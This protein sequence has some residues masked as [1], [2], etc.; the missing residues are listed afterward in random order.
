MAA[1][2]NGIL[3]SRTTHKKA[4]D[5][6]LVKA[7]EKHYEHFIWDSTRWHG[8][9]HRPDDILVCTAYKAGTTW[10]QRICSLL[11][12]QST[13]LVKP[14]TTF[15][16]WLELNAQP[17]EKLHADYA[18]QAHRRFIKTHTPLDGLPW[19]DAA[20]Y[21][22]VA[23]DPRDIFL[24]MLNH[25]ANS[26]DAAGEILL[27]QATVDRVVLAKPPE[28]M[29]ELL[30]AWL[31]VGTVAGETDGWPFWS[32][33]AHARSF[34]AARHHSNLL[35]LHYGDLIADLDGQMRRISAHLGI[36]I[37]EAI[38]PE[39][40]EAAGFNSM[41]SSADLMAPDVDWGSWKNNQDFFKQGGIGN[42][43][44][45]FSTDDLALYERHVRE[46][47]PADLYEW[48]HHSGV[49]LVPDSTTV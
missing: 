27:E 13:E 31:T 44:T 15:S 6:G 29:S 4:D 32:A 49:T 11:V 3:I 16:P 18:A 41:K 20:R 24:S 19:S 21:L 45:A 2:F 30:E 14:L 17:A 36:P 39:L 42:W 23:R 40:V 8:F 33:F 9:Q 38:W 25:L 28:T 47:L 37:N 34:W 26:N 10:T 43:Q 48:I 12:F 5:M 7:P 22:F 1:T 46:K 35:C